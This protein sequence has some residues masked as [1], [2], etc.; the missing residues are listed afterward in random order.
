MRE[1][2]MYVMKHKDRKIL[3]SVGSDMYEDQVLQLE[4]R[5]SNPGIVPVGYE[6]RP[7]LIANL[8]FGKSDF[9]WVFSEMNAITD[10]F[11]EIN[12]GDE[13]RLP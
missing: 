10:P 13:I 3:T 6:H 1:K 11:E 8:F 4:T 2:M 5:K 7:D 12:I 9:W